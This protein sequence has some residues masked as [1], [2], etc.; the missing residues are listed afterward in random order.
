MREPSV[1]ARVLAEGD[2]DTPLI[3]FAHG[4]E[5]RWTS[6]LPV[7]EQVP[8]GWRMVALD[9][10]WRAGNDYRWRARAPGRWLADGLD[11]LDAVPDVLV[12]H[13]FGAGAVLEL[14]CTA[15]PGVR[16]TALLCP[17]YRRPETRVTW[18]MLDRSRRRFLDQVRDGVL[19]RMGDRAASMEPGLL[20]H[21]VTLAQQRV[22]PSGFLAA[23]EQFVASADLPLDRVRPPALVLAGGA[24]P[25]LSRAEATAL[26]D[27][28][29]AGRLSFHETY[30][31]FCH[32]RCAHEVAAQVMDLAEAAPVVMLNGEPR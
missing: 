9:L 22:S 24:N 1:R 17:L 20:E 32:I 10:P 5:D 8:P 23:F 15:P 29:P 16:A 25:T 6:W 27:R 12:G 7:A 21:I 30:D 14:L 11:M 13:S 31:H 2:G 4:L 19:A 28:M 3:A 26:A 18:R